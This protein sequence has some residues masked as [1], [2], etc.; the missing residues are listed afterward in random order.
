MDLMRDRDGQQAGPVWSTR[1]RQGWTFWRVCFLPAQIQM[2]AAQQTYCGQLRQ[3]L[4][5][6]AD[7]CHVQQ[8]VLT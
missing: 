5:M 2:Q 1:L 8:D 3:H 6:P 4:P 7:A